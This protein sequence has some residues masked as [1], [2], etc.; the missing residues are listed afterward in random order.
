MRPVAPRIGG[1]EIML[2]EEQT[3]Y[4][5]LPAT[6]VAIGDQLGLCTRWTFTPEERAQIAA[7]EDLFLDIVSDPSQLGVALERL[8]T[9]RRDPMGVD[10]ESSGVN[11][12][13]DLVGG[14][15]L[16]AGDSA[17]YAYGEALGPAVRFL[18]DQVR[19][20]RALVTHA[21][22][23]DLHHLYRT[24]GLHVPYPID[25]SMVLSFIVD[26]RGAKLEGDDDEPDDPDEIVT[27]SKKKK[28]RRHGLKELS[29]MHH[30]PHAADEEDVLMASVFAA[31]GRGKEDL[32]AGHPRLLGRYGA[33]DAWDCLQLRHHFKPQLRTSRGFGQVQSQAELYENEQWLLLALVDMERRG[34]RID[35]P[36]L[37][38]W[39]RD[40][41]IKLDACEARM[42]KL[43]GNNVEWGSTPQLGDLLYRR[44]KL[45]VVRRTKKKDAPSTDE[46]TLLKLQ[47]LHPFIK[48]LL[49]WRDLFK[50]HKTYALGLL[51][52]IAP[53]GRIHCSFKQ[54]G[55]RTGR[56][57]CADP[58]L[59]QVPRESGARRA[60]IPDDGCFMD[61][62]DYSQIEMRFAAHETNE[63]TLVRGFN[64]DPD[65]DT[66]QATAIVMYGVRSPT[67]QQ[68]KFA[69]ITNFLTIY[70]GGVNKL[71]ES[72]MQMLDVPT[73]VHSL[74]EMGIA[75]SDIDQ[76]EPHAQLA[77]KIMERYHRSLPRVKP[78]AR[79]ITN[80]VSELGYTENAF[81]RRR[82][83]PEREAYK[84]FNSKVQ[85]NA[86]DQA[87]R[88]LV[89]LYRELQH[90]SGD[91]ALQLQ[92]HDEAVYLNDG[93]PKVRKRVLELLEDR[94]SFRIPIL[95]D[96]KFTTT[97]WME[98]TK[99]VA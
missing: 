17:V 61:F 38:G 75:R 48:E 87:K 80:S 98:K 36:F 60:F 25:D 79:S 56:L 34:V 50:Q 46:V 81:G 41:K 32:L 49:T 53:D 35:Q 11:K 82:Y 39:E 52:A 3:E 51:A 29:G 93:D 6:P 73:A 59:Q 66:H 88:G 14:L 83:L 78:T 94:D 1:E 5:T 54:T 85:G 62:A 70:G 16:A 92:I 72:L 55:A 13:R 99:W 42:R 68:R 22:K 47:H 96:L 23:G 43:V 74:R 2:A 84:G 20:R 37:E 77:G 7:G 89:K 91:I 97:N 21:G 26:N 95:A 58:N 71:T 19:Q 10:V 15:S 86:G 31:G 69:K 65:F 28:E 30:R 63:P 67:P 40:L 33:F 90:G 24:F 8:G 27:D 76:R 64:K 4:R 9:D 12:Q 57:S 18:S 44:L 45:P